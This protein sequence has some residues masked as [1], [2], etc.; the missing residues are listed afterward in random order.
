MTHV[1]VRGSQF[2]SVLH[3]AKQASH[4]VLLNPQQPIFFHKTNLILFYGGDFVSLVLQTCNIVPEYQRFEC[5]IL[6]GEL[7]AGFLIFGQFTQFS[8]LGLFR[9]Y[10]PFTLLVLPVH[11][12]IMPQAPVEKF[13]K[14]TVQSC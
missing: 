5:K 3:H 2:L 11:E 10:E 7:E 9:V 8:N 14:Y 6:V 4:Q 1:L 12:T 13:Q